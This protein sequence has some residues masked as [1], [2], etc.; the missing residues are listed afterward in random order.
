MMSAR[1]PASTVLADEAIQWTR[2]ILLVTANLT[3][4]V[5]SGKL[6]CKFKLL[7]LRRR[8]QDGAVASSAV[9]STQGA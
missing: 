9:A 2:C 1:C 4:D 6:G 3:E 5:R 8:F 7:V